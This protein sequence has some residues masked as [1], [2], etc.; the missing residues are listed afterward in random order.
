[1]TSKKVLKKPIKTSYG[2]SV[3]IENCPI[4][5]EISNNL[6]LNINYLKEHF[7]DCSDVVFRQLQIKDRSLYCIYTD[8]M[9][10]NTLLS[11]GV[12][13]SLL[14]HSDIFSSPLMV[15]QKI[16]EA[17]P[18]GQ[19]SIK[20]DIEQC[21]H[22]IM[23]GSIVLL[24]QG[25]HQA[26][27]V[28]IPGWK[29]RGI[30]PPEVEPTIRGPK[31]SFTETLNINMSLI[32]KRLLHQDCKFRNLFIGRYSKTR[33]TVS[34]IDSIA[35]KKI[36][37]EVVKRLERINVDSSLDLGYLNE[38]IQDNPFS[39][40]PDL[41]VTERPDKVASALLEGRVAI[42]QENSPSAILAPALFIN[43]LQS[44]EDYYNRFYIGSLLRYLRYMG[45]AITILLPSFYIAVSTFNQELIPTQLLIT[46]AAQR[47][48]V[49]FP[50]SV[51][52]I[53]MGL[54]FEILREA[55]TRLPKS[56]GQAV[57]IV[58]ALIIGDAA[59]TAGLVSP[60]M[61]IVTAITAISSFTLPSIELTDPIFILRI[62]FVLL[63]TFLGFWGIFIGLVLLLAHLVSLR[64]FGVPYMTPLSPIHLQDLD[65]VLY[66]APQWA[67]NTRPHYF[68]KLNPRRQSRN[69]KPNSQKQSK[70]DNQ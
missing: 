23:Y 29:S 8:G 4:L 51:E 49:P 53:F 47:E 62:L 35:N 65:D 43:F 48:G 44:S 42:L 52:S 40:F 25:F 50:A 45:L 63:S 32:R 27:V 64:S 30:S 69:L 11:E 61:V 22:S 36:V 5:T 10:D 46:L 68:G 67:M 58:G 33:V 59:V 57:S 31:E 19:V 1:M 55:G 7:Q 3:P 20:T 12:L 26:I 66:R 15:E 54:A 2:K 39:P 60:A 14:H 70:G 17:L 56:I 6:E 37:D 38:L 18:I 9:V 13:K 24:I 41:Q 28:T 21:L 16:Q 34:Y